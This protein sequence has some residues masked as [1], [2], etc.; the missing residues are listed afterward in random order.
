MTYLDSDVLNGGFIV[1][2]A[3]P[4][5]TIT[6]PCASRRHPLSPLTARQCEVLAL[7]ARG[8]RAK[9]VADRLGLSVRTIEKH[10]QDLMRKLRVRTTV[11]L[12]RWYL[13]A[14]DRHGGV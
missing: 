5:P 3:L 10:K 2:H 13:A 11:E 8:L 12:L 4:A 9:Q 6:E 1:A 7:T 14:S